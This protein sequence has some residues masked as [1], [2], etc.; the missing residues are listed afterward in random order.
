MA[1]LENS[2][3]L[4]QCVE[5]KLSCFVNSCKYFKYPSYA[6][7][8]VKPN[9]KKQINARTIPFFADIIKSMRKDSSVFVVSG[10]IFGAFYVNNE[11][12]RWFTVGDLATSRVYYNTDFSDKLLESTGNDTASPLFSQNDLASLSLVS[13]ET[14]IVH[15]IFLLFEFSQAETDLFPKSNE[16]PENPES[17]T[18]LWNSLEQELANKIKKSNS[19]KMARYNGENENERV[20][21]GYK[22]GKEVM[23]LVGADSPSSL[24]PRKTIYVHPGEA[25]KLTSGELEPK[26][27]GSN[28]NSNRLIYVLVSGN[29]KFGEL[30]LKKVFSYDETTLPDWNQVN[31]IYMEKSIR[32]FTQLDLL[33]GNVW[34]EPYNDLSPSRDKNGCRSRGS[35]PRKAC[36]PGEVCDDDKDC[37]PTSF[38]S[39]DQSSTNGPKY[40]HCMFEVYDQDNLDKLI[41]KEIIHFNIQTN[42]INE[43]FLGLEVMRRNQ[44]T[45]L[46]RRWVSLN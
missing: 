42:V 17:R 7:L 5:G 10:P 14:G 34:Y 4:C 11:R 12:T 20:A 40:D 22:Y 28:V 44:A 45:G 8:K 13:S 35:Q 21:R 19:K 15:N 2:C 46:Y 36:E 37:D 33:K 18:Q 25:V 6:H 24:P 23:S 41:S 3:K 9:Q 32:E 29:L 16:E 39:S 1:Q 43:T 30:K 26:N 38:S 27:L 31:D